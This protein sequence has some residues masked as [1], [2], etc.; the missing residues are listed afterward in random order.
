LDECKA[1]CGIMI[2]RYAAI[3]GSSCRRRWGT[4]RGMPCW[5]RLRDWT[6]VGVWQKL[7][8]LLLTRRTGRTCWTGRVRRSVGHM[9]WRSRGHKAARA[10][11]T[12]PLSDR[13]AM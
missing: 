3:R 1:S 9:C 11:W 10:P 6:G 4:G 13:H 8:E 12:G 2:V 5:R 7:H